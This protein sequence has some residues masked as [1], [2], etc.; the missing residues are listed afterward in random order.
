MNKQEL[1][2]PVMNYFAENIN[3]QK[4]W[5]IATDCAR[6]ICNLNFDQII[7]GGFDM[8]PPA[9]MKQN[10]AD[11]V[12]YEFDASDFMQNGPVDFSELDESSVSEVMAKIESIYK[13][14]HDAQTMVVA[15]AACN[16]CDSLVNS[17]K[18]EIRQI[19]EKYLSKDRD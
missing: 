1:E 13:K 4:Y 14:F 16:M 19:K 5:D 12:P 17:V 8:P 6:D 9:E 7:S 15:R 11:K 2:L 3:L 18:K 10:L